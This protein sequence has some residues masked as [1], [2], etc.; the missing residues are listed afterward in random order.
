V[1][2]SRI[3]INR[4][5]RETLRA[6][7]SPQILHAAVEACFP[8]AD[9][10][11]S[12]NLWRIDRLNRSLYLLLQSEDKPDFTHITEQFGWL[13]QTWET[14]EYDGFLSG[15]RNGQIWNF[16]LQANPTRSISL[17]KDARGKV[18]GLVTVK[19]Q[20]DWFANRAA[21]HGF[22]IGQTKQGDLIFDV[23]QNEIRH[24]Q[25]QG[26]M[27]TFEAA[28]FEGMLR[29]VDAGSLVNAMKKGIG[30]AKAYGCGLLTLARQNNE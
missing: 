14:K 1:Y 17:E 21:K 12:R 7:A 4:R 15:L 29:I 28:V 23:V 6:L 13:G 16:R 3:E 5:K 8:T 9:K 19:L 27:V 26:K 10:T 18:V 22:E 11:D 2:L 24:F 20:K 30:R 25:R